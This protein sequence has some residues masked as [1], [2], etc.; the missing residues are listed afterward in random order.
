MKIEVVGNC[1][2]SC[3]A[4]YHAI[5]EAASEMGEGIEVVHIENIADI[6]RFGVIQMPTVI[7]D[8]KQVSAGQHYTKEEART[9]LL[10]R[11]S[12]R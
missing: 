4:T 2:S 1:C 8:G 7:I 10:S 5:K 6:L 9:L 11:S 3:H 12:K